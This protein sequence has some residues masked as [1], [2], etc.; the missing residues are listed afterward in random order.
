M[1]P[2]RAQTP[3]PLVRVGLLPCVIGVISSAQSN[4]R[5]SEVDLAYFCAGL[6]VSRQP[7]ARTASGADALTMIRI[8]DPG[9]E[10]FYRRLI[11]ALL[12]TTEMTQP[13]PHVPTIIRAMIWD[14]LA[15]T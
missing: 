13:F 2:I 8:P 9:M 12:V 10:A 14:F 15:R 1:R 11:G 4:G 7:L 6:Q 5:G 3:V